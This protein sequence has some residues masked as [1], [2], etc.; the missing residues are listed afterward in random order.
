MKLL[1]VRSRWSASGLA[2]AL[3]AQQ[4]TANTT[5]AGDDKVV[6]REVWVM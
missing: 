6:T 2:W 3:K 4:M 1:I 5:D